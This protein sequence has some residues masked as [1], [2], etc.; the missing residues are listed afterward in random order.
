VFFQ[1]HIENLCLTGVI[2][3]LSKLIKSCVLRI[4]PGNWY[5]ILAEKLTNGG[6]QIWCELPQVSFIKFNVY[7]L[8]FNPNSSDT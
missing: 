3:T 6:V 4:T 1:I 7:N 5:F 2:G 8:F